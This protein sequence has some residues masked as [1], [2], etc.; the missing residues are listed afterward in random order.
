MVTTNCQIDKSYS[1]SNW[2]CSGEVSNWK[3]F[4]ELGSI[5]QNFP[6]NRKHISC[7][8]AIVK[9]LLR[10]RRTCGTKIELYHTT[11]LLTLPDP[12]PLHST[13]P[14]PPI[15]YLITSDKNSWLYPIKILQGTVFRP[16]DNHPV[17]HYQYFVQ[18]IVGKQMITKRPSRLFLKMFGSN[19]ASSTHLLCSSYDYVS[20]SRT[21]RDSGRFVLTT[22]VYLGN[23]HY[24]WIW[25]DICEEHPQ[26]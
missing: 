12:T 16:D 9:T 8:L 7:G 22:P 14:H 25:Q 17:D 18:I 23:L 15:S 1:I 11:T 10:N 6:V 13:T 21:E 4:I 24:K 20:G 5:P 2:H 19:S 26:W 3:Y